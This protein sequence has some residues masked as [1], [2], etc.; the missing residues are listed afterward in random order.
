[1]LS[2]ERLEAHT[3]TDRM[4]QKKKTEVMESDHQGSSPGILPFAQIFFKA[5]FL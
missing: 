2:K 3:F 5:R 4:I 1:M